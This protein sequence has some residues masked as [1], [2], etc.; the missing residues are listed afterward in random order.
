MSDVPDKLSGLLHDLFQIFNILQDIA[1]FQRVICIKN[2][3]AG[4]ASL[5]TEFKNRTIFHP[6]ISGTGENN[7]VNEREVESS[8]QGRIEHK[9][10]AVRSRALTAISAATTVP[11]LFPTNRIAS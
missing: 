10:N 7:G 6:W 4:N 2:N 3:M 9:V 1:G 8:F 5:P 11:M